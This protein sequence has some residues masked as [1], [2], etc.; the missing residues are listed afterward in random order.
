MG[1]LNK[2]KWDK[3]NWWIYFWL[4]IFIGDIKSWFKKDDTVFFS[5]QSNYCQSQI[6]YKIKL[7]INW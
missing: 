4:F 5:R 3:R 7:K 1:I 6:I 2:I